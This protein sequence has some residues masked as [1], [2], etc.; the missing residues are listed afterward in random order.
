MSNDLELTLDID[1]PKE[2]I[3]KIFSNENLEIYKKYIF[4]RFNL[5]SEKRDNEGKKIIKKTK[6]LSEIKKVIDFNF[7]FLGLTLGGKYHFYIFY[8][9]IPNMLY[10]SIPHHG[11]QQNKTLLLEVIE[12]FC[13]I[14]K[15]KSLYEG[16]YND[17]DSIEEIREL[18]KSNHLIITEYNKDSKGIDIDL[19]PQITEIV[20]KY[21]N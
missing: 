15:P 10:I 19:T 11:Q 8:N 17:F 16:G 14:L 18:Q 1:L 13:K 7:N 5:I 2:E 12:D 9:T 4:K 3:V 6:I 20:N 21:K